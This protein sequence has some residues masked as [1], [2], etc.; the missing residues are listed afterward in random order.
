MTLIPVLPAV[1]A[2]HVLPALIVMFSWAL[3]ALVCMNIAVKGKFLKNQSL[4]FVQINT[5]SS[6]YTLTDDHLLDD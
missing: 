2:I 3:H 1:R 5:F 4:N 6:K